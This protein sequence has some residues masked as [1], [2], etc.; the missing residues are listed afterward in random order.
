MDAR[1]PSTSRRPIGLKAGAMANGKGYAYVA[2]GETKILVH[3]D[4]PHECSSTAAAEKAKLELTVRGAKGLTLMLTEV[5]GATILLHKYPSC[6]IRINVLVLRD[7]GGL[8]HAA[9]V[10]SSLAL[11]SAG[12]ELFDMCTAATI[13]VAE[14]G[15]VFFD[16]PTDFENQH[17]NSR[18]IFVAVLP[19][20][21]QIL[22][23]KASGKMTAAETEKYAAEA[24]AQANRLLPFM[25]KCLEVYAKGRIANEKQ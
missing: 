20:L 25:K 3:A 17:K 9:V 21:N 12:I 16:P 10:A 18:R 2:F 22:H 11:M 4:G 5:M 19:G 13:M 14:D 7:D 24:S 6:T 15:Q 23:C 8:E 1:K